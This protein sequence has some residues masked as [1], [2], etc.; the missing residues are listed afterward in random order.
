LLLLPPVSSEA[1][2]NVAPTK[3]SVVMNIAP[4]SFIASS[5]VGAR[6]GRL[7]GRIQ[8]CEECVSDVT[9]FEA[10]LLTVDLVDE[11]ARAQ[12]E[13]ARR[14]SFH[15]MQTLRVARERVHIGTRMTLS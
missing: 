14:S 12:R 13:I 1:Q 7:F 3:V 6:V 4:V 15:S 5:S 9:T 2:P 8:K 11:R 10:T